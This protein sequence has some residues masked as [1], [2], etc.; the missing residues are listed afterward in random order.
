[1]AVKQPRSW[2]RMESKKDEPDAADI[3]VFDF[4]GDWIDDYWGF[5]VTAKSFVDELAKLPDSVKTIRLHV[6]SPG[7][8]VFG[9]VTIAN[10][11]RDQRTSKGR[12]VDV[13]IEG[14]AASAATIITCAGDTVRIS[15]NA[16]MMVHNP[17]WM[18]VGNAADMRKA[19]DELDKIR[20]TIIATYRWRS[21]LSEEALGAL[22]DAETWMGADEAIEQGFADEKVEGLKAAASIDPHV[23]AK[24]KVPEKY[25]A[26]IDALAKPAP[27]PEPP[28]ATDTAA[29]PADVL[30]ECKTAGCLDLAEELINAKATLETVQARTGEAKQQ[31]QAAEARER[32]IR[33][34]CKAA[35]QDD[36]ADDYVKNGV[37]VEFVRANLTRI[38][39]KLDR[40]EIDT[41]LPP[42]HGH[43]QRAQLDPVAIYAE[44]NNPASTNGGKA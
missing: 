41:Q 38:A 33:N 13:M 16:M 26:R 31:R 5:G 35:K 11:L 20:G 30:R 18:A 28:A 10:A 40:V 7:G 14:L 6:N 24:L 8:D 3:Y 9:A 32:E 39:A 27:V 42:D 34:L 22:M 4:I 37:S 44:R 1:M 36:L 17:W 12:T 19:A 43:T 25:Q 21:S 15:D 23:V 2:F 29:A